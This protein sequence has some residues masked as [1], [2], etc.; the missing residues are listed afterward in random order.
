MTTCAF[1]S[2]AGFAGVGTGVAVAAATA[3]ALGEGE[4]FSFCSSFA[5]RDFALLQPAKAM[6]RSTAKTAKRLS[7]KSGK[8]FNSESRKHK[9]FL[10]LERDWHTQCAQ[11]STYAGLSPEN[12]GTRAQFSRDSANA[13]QHRTS[14]LDRGLSRP[15]ELRLERSRRPQEHQ[16]QLHHGGG[17]CGTWRQ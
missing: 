2:I 6:G 10:P 12:I 17:R 4:P 3:V 11:S 15:G 13:Q 1:W 7:I 8:G 9:W 14:Q 16:P 5:M